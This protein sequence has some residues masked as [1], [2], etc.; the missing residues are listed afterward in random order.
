MGRIILCEPRTAVVPYVF[1]NTMVEVYTYEELCYYIYNNM[2]LLIPEHFRDKF[3]A[4]LETELHMDE[5]AKKVR[6]RQKDEEP[7]VNILVTILSEGSY[8]TKKEI[9]QI[10]DKQ[11]MLAM[12][13][14]DEKL[15]MQGDSFLTYQRLLK[16]ISLY[17]EILRHENKIEDQRFLGDVYHNRG[18]ALAKN[19]EITN[20]KLAFLKAYER[21]QRQASLE[22]YIML[23]LVENEDQ[24]L[25]KEEAYGLGLPE[26]DTVRLINIVEDAVDDSKAT[27]IYK[28]YEKAL[29]NRDK[30]DF[31]GYN[32]RVD[33]LLNEWKTE[34]RE[35]V[36]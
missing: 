29:F 33:M 11:D 10:K 24:E 22:S 6:L 31:E 26:A 30:G 28:R 4:W 25:V 17:D 21:N 13:S 9:E 8:Y 3:T 32:Q 36:V 23:R 1:N 5:L 14:T 34:F 18:V 35:Q 7:F 19:M 16:A 20:A 2:I 12:L 15:K 27:A